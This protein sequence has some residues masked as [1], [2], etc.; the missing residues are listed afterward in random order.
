MVVGEVIT[1]GF[2]WLPVIPLTIFLGLIQ[3][4]FIHKDE[5][6]R[7]SH[8]FTHGIHILLIM[9]IFL[10]AVFNTEYFLDLAGLRDVAY[11]NNVWVVRSIIGLIFGIKSYVISSVIKGGTGSRGMHEGIFHV[12]LMAVLVVTAPLYWPI[13]EQFL[14]SWAGG[15][16]LVEGG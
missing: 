15:P 16:Q 5:P 1:Q 4:I 8:W 2:V 3:L 11:I 14:P 7:G 6:F 9:P 13:I 12:L 10:L